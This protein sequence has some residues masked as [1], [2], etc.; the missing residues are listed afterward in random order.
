MRRE[1][2]LQQQL[3][4]VAFVDLSIKCIL[5]ASTLYKRPEWMDTMFLLIFF[6]CIAWKLLLQRYTKPMLIG[7]ALFGILFAA[8]SFRMSYFFLLFTFCGLAALQNVDIKG[9]LKYTSIAKI[10]MILLHVIPYIFVAVL[11][12]EKIVYVYRNGVQRQ[13][14]YLGHPNTFSM[15]VGWALLEFTYA[16]YER[17]KKW[18]L[19]S[20][21]LINYVVYQFTDSNTSLII[22]TFCLFSFFLEKRK[23]NLIA[24]FYTPIA[25]YGY[26]VCMIFF[27][28]ITIWFTKMP[29]GLKS[30]Y[31]TL[32]DF[33]TGRLLYGAYTYENFGIAWLGN[34]NVALHGKAYFEGFWIDNLVYDNSYIFL[35]VKYG[36]IFLPI[37]AVGFW[38]L[39]KGKENDTSKNLETIMLVAYTFFSIMENYSV[40]AVLCFPVLFIGV[41][42]FDVYE[43]KQQNKI[44]EK[45]KQREQVRGI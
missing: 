9:V 11:E 39:Q 32:N 40:N 27:T 31:L 21:W 2:I 28:V 8:A 10:I 37:F 44:K 41:K 14:F 7:T 20:F 38:W 33:F 29:A 3:Y 12:P 25:Q 13:F 6:G 5:D 18:H 36:A 16:Y 4:T 19:V 43:E 23:P 45:E 34:P 42:I 30:A 17:L 35:L 15:Y 1:K 24:K 22:A 26:T